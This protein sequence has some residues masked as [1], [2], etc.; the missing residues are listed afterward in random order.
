MDNRFVDYSFPDSSSKTLE[1]ILVADGLTL[2]FAVFS[3]V[4]IWVV[5]PGSVGNPTIGGQTLTTVPQEKS[6]IFDSTINPNGTGA[7]LQLLFI[8]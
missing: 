2:H 1:D 4:Y 8:S 7:R 6:F 3:K 5:T